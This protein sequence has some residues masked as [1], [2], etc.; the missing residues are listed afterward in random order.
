MNNQRKLKF[1]SH[2]VD[3][4]K[5]VIYGTES[6]ILESDKFS[7]ISL[8]QSDVDQQYPSSNPAQ[9]NRKSFPQSPDEVQIRSPHSNSPRSHRLQSSKVNHCNAPV[10]FFCFARST[11]KL[12]SILVECSKRAKS[13]WRHRIQSISA[14]DSDSWILVTITRSRVFGILVVFEYSKRNCTA[15]TN[16][17]YIVSIYGPNRARPISELLRAV[18]FWSRFTANRWRAAGYA[19]IL[20]ANRSE[21]GET[22]GKPIAS[23]AWQ[24]PLSA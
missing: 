2:P 22:R 13:T 15:G 8:D 12:R 7:E 16:W 4:P 14:S 23:I 6:A 5:S 24:Q 17:R 10:D 9:T 18:I 19:C 3:T 1:F 20:L 21:F 11:A